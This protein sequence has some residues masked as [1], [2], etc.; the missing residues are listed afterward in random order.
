MR[1]SFR[2]KG[3]HFWQSVDAS[4]EDVSV[5]I[6]YYININQKTYGNTVTTNVTWYKIAV[7]MVNL[8]SLIKKNTF[9]PL[10]SVTDENIDKKVRNW[11]NIKL[12]KITWPNLTFYFR[13][14]VTF[15]DLKKCKYRQYKGIYY[16]N[17]MPSFK[18]LVFPCSVTPCYVI[19][20]LSM[21]QGLRR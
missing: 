13:V 19:F 6:S 18:L 7:D 14:W 21:V 15:W 4:L 2:S 1:H 8:K 16:N 10:T 20:S 3:R 5:T 17:T 12:R 9:V 11:H